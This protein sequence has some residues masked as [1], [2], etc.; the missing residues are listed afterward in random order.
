MSSKEYVTLAEFAVRVNVP[1]GSLYHRSRKNAIPG[2]TRL[3]PRTIRIH[4]PTYLAATTQR[5]APAA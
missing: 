2:M 5:H 3:A 1:L 4:M